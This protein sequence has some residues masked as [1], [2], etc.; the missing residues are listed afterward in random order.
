M[1]IVV[2]GWEAAMAETRLLLRES[3]VKRHKNLG[4]KA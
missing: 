3:R 2:G 4:Q 1:V